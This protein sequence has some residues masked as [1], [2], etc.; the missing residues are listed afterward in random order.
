MMSTS[1]GKL[2]RYPQF[3]AVRCRCE[4]PRAQPDHH[5]VLDGTGIGVDRMHEIA[6][7][8]SDV[9]GFTVIADQ[10]AFRLRTGRD[11]FHDG[12]PVQ[13]DDRQRRSLFVGDIDS[14]A[15]LVDGEGL[16]ARAGL[17]LAD[18]LQLRHVENVDDVVVAAGDV[19]H[20]VIGAK[21]HVAR[22]ARDLDVTHHFVG[23]WIDDDD[24]VGLLV[25]DENQAGIF[26][27][28]RRAGE[29]GENDGSEFKHCIVSKASP[30]LSPNKPRGQG[31]SRG[32]NDTR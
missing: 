28:R 3:F 24:V 21:V 6:G 5:V 27:Q 1:A 29:H 23:L 15:L 4:A 7:L 18:D 26:C 13:V 22:P 32:T 12:V 11:F 9:D 20:A 10:N 19:K 16:G 2:R 8:G 31:N 14:A 30:K 17:E 25:A